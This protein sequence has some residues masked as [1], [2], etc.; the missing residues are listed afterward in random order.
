M[1]ATCTPRKRKRYTLN[2]DNDD[3]LLTD[4]SSSKLRCAENLFPS[5]N[6]KHN[7]QSSVQKEDK[8]CSHQLHFPSSP[9]KTT[10]NSRFSFANH[11]S[12]FKPAMSTVSFYS[13]EKY[14]LNPLERKLIRECRSICLATESGDKPI[15]SVTENIQ[16]KPVCTKKN[17]K[18]QKSLTAKYQPNYKHIKSKSRNLKNSKPNQVT[19]K[20]VVDQENSCFPAKNYPNSPPR[21]LSQKIKPQVTLQGGAAF[22]VRK[23]NSLKKLPLEDKPLLLQKNLPEVPE[24]APEAKQ[25]PKSLLVDEK[26]SVKVQN[27]RSKNEEKLRKNPSGAV[28]SSKEC[29]LDKHDFP[30]ENSLDENKTISPESVYPIFNVSSVNTKR[31]EE[32]S[33]VGST[34]CTNFL[35]QTN[36]PKNINSR[37]TNKGGKDQLV[38]DAGQKHFG[39]TVCKSCGM[40]YT[41]SNPEDEIQHLQHHHRFLEGIKFVGWKRERVVAEFWDGKI[42]LVLPRDPSYAIKK[43]EDVQELVDL[44]LGFQQTVPVC[45]DKTKTFLFIDEKRVVG[46]LIAEPIKQAFRVLSEPSASKECSRAWRCSDVPE[47]AICGISR[48]WVFRLKRRKR[49]ARRLVDT[50]RNCFM[51]GCFLSTNEIAFSDPTPDGK[52]FATKYCNTPNFLVYNFH[53]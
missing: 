21:V 8:S 52:L 33:S 19:Y 34:A 40:I 45:P 20:P 14:Y 13:K 1:M 51:F 5:P 10:E 32:Q 29:N 47:P 24:G 35:K 30:S 43:V 26:S 39:T 11:S 36:V 38:I 46:C 48:I 6:K 22:F 42:V 49:I 53:N 28:V 18:K 41:A 44:E 3:S 7:Y 25:I 16:R 31:P 17:K 27:A 2:A 12:L 4:I 15:P 9:L 37:D 50:V 23:R